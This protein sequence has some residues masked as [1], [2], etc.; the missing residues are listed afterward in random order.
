[1]FGSWSSMPFVYGITKPT[2]NAN[3][4][5]YS[6]VIGIDIDIGTREKY[7]Y[8]FLFTTPYEPGLIFRK[9]NVMLIKIA[10]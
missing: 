4:T 3:G 7:Q 8:L 2:L 1:M 6:V 9:L 10:K 5:L